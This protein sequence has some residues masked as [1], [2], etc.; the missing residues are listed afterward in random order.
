M[1][2]ITRRSFVKLIGAGGAASLLGAVGCAP[3]PDA[4]AAPAAPGARVVVVGGGFG[5]ATCAKYLRRFDPEID[6]TLVEADPQFVT[7]PG[8]NW[9]L[10]GLR[11]MDYI[12]VSF[13]D[14]RTM[15]GVQVVQD[16]VTAIDPAA[17]RLSLAGGSDLQY[18]YLVLSPG[19]AIRWGALE[20]YDEAA[21]EVMPHAWK[22]GPQTVLLRRQLEAMEDGGT[23]IITAPAGAYRCPPGPYERAAMIAHYLSQH[24]PRS[25]IL[26][27]DAKEDF[28][29]Q[30]LFMDGW[31]AL[32]PGMIEWVPGT[33]GGIVNRVDPQTMTVFTQEGLEEHRGDVI[34]VVPPQSAA[35][36]AVAT[37]LTNEEGWCPINQE[38]FESTIHPRIHVIGD[39]AIAGGMPKSGHS[40]NNQAKMTAAAI[41]SAIRDIELPSPSHVN[42]CYSLIGPEYGISIAAVY[43]LVDGVI[44]GI[45]GSGGVSPRETD[46]Q[47]RM[48]EARYAEGW[49]D[50]IRQD[51]W[52]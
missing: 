2:H 28:S 49:Y 12:T 18:D 38:T 22:A 44:T 48:L 23:V 6:V 47:Y 19:I 39:A 10:A 8:S 7:C 40:A 1:K 5:G 11:D 9:V 17:R 35:E 27:L 24:K 52:A 29:K 37:G 31:E 30:G 51:S 15:H 34:N 36:I 41:V 21:A 3:R 32:Y 33:Q 4:L 26:I 20:G 42:T 50:A 13:D 46:A 43:R 25:K 45:E 14:L 16:T